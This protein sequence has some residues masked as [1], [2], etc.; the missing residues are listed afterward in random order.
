MLRWGAG[1]SLRVAL[2]VLFAMMLSGPALAREPGSHDAPPA[3]RVASGEE[4]PGDGGVTV[5]EENVHAG[6]VT[7]LPLPAATA[8]SHAPSLAQAPGVIA[9]LAPSFG[10]SATAPAGAAAFVL[11]IYPDEYLRYIPEIDAPE[12]WLTVGEVPDTAYYAGDFSGGD[13]SQI[14]VIDYDLNQLHTLDTHSGSR[15][16]VG[17]CAPRSGHVWTGVTGAADGTLYAS[18]LAADGSSSYLYTLNMASGAATAVGQI[19]N[20]ASVIDIAINA[21]GEMYGV[22]IA[23][24]DL[25]RIDPNTAAGSVIGPIGFDADYAQGMDFDPGSGVLYLAAYNA[26]Y[27]RGEL[28]TVDLSTGSSVLIDEFPDGVQAD[29]LAFTPPP[30]QRV[31]NPGFE[32]G[33]ASW[34]AEGTPFLSGTSHSGSRSVTMSGE[35][36]WVWQE[37]SIPADAID[38]TLAFWLTGVSADP[39]WDNDIFYGGIWDV[40]RTTEYASGS[41]G[42]TYF[43]SYPMKW[44]RRIFRLDVDEL[45]SIAGKRVA[46]AFGV[47]Q[48]WN[49]GYHKVSTAYLDDTVLY[50]TRPIYAY[51]VYLP[52]VV[53]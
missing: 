44:R 1:K 49:P 4:P 27:A 2:L 35:E 15:T 46:V 48:D 18:S 37:V 25:V 34:D 30:A 22:D 23:T 16:V 13:F 21:D 17:P 45:A 38:V 14:Y 28:R 6:T 50:V 24:D 47:M 40:T 53:R 5:T 26:D 7:E 9:P 8:A 33:W 10:S 29:A 12:E 20:A 41:F 42:L 3:S 43:Y 39:D 51:G 36:E 19:T 52:L 31:V 11:E 32:S